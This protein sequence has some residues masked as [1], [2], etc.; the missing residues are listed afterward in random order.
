M[1]PDEQANEAQCL[2]EVGQYGAD[3]LLVLTLEGEESI[4]RLFHYR[5]LLASAHTDIGTELLVVDPPWS[6]SE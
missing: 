5:L 4:S 3:D 2:F 6:L 1:S